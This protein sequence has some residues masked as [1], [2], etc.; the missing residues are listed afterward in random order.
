MVMLVGSPNICP[1]T[2]CSPTGGLS[3]DVDMNSLSLSVSDILNFSLLTSLSL[4]RSYAV[5]LRTGHFS[6]TLAATRSHTADL[7]IIVK[8]P[9]E[10]RESLRTIKDC[11]KV[12]TISSQH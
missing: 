4:T 1:Y 6:R 10:R 12:G 5:T 3:V 7:M 11:L 2:V 9:R 8:M